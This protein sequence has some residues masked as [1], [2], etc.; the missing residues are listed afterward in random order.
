VQTTKAAILLCLAMATGTGTWY[1]QV[2]IPDN[3]WRH[4][5]DAGRR[6]MDQ[7]NVDEAERQFAMAVETARR[8]GRR[9][10]RL[11][12]SLLDRARALVAQDRRA[13]AIPVLEQALAIEEKVHG[14]DHQETVS[15]LQYYSDLLHGSGPAAG[16]Q[17]ADE[18]TARRGR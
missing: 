6:S 7:G 3:Q 11:A 5:N 2:R 16:A 17:A 14:L 4:S 1:L 15:V 13:E 12:R 18:P 8:F 9:D 10:L